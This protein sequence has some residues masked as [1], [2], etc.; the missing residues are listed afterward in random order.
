[1]FLGKLFKKKPQNDQIYNAK[2]YKYFI[3]PECVGKAP[4]ADVVVV[5]TEERRFYDSKWVVITPHFTVT[6]TRCD[7]ETAERLLDEIMNLSTFT[8]KDIKS[9]DKREQIYYD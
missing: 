3:S 6:I 8:E 5:K 7:G 4:I 2:D 9:L 1:M